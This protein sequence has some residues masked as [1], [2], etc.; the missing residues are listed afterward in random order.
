LTTKGIKREIELLAKIDMEDT[1]NLEHS[2]YLTFAIF[3]KIF[4]GDYGADG[5]SGLVSD[6]IV[7]DS[8]ITVSRKN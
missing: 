3:A 1:D 7:L 2:S 8:K 5:Y 6:K 4:I